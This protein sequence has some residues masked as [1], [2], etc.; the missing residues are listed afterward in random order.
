MK[1]NMVRADEER[2][3]S[4]AALSKE[5]LDQSRPDKDSI[6]ITDTFR[7][8]GRRSPSALQVCERLAMKMFN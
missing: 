3:E 2:C 5:R 4:P 6:A 7:L 8:I 1:G